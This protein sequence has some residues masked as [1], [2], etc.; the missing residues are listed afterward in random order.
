[1]ALAAVHTSGSARGVFDIRLA[2]RGDDLRKT[3]LSFRVNSQSLW[4]I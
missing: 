2:K 1:V 3:I 4:P